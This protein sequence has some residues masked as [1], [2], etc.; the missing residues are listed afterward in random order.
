MIHFAY[1]EKAYSLKKFVIIVIHIRENGLNIVTHYVYLT[2][3]LSFGLMR[4]KLL[5]S[6]HQR[7]SLVGV[8]GMTYYSKKM[9][10]LP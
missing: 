5:L 3:Q 2:D 7:I 8:L 4:C 6:Y 9:V 1:L 10:K